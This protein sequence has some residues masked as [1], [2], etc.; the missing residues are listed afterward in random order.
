[1][2][3]L[4]VGVTLNPNE[5]Q[6]LCQEIS[7]NGCDFNFVLPS[8]TKEELKIQYQMYKSINPVPLGMNVSLVKQLLQHANFKSNCKKLRKIHTES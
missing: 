2:C 3:I 8:I 6:C 5:N 1:M 7:V 4:E